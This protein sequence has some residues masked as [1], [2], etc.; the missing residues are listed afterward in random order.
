M[1]MARLARKNPRK[2]GR[3]HCGGRRIGKGKHYGRGYHGKGMHGKGM[4]GMGLMKKLKKATRRS[5]VRKLMNTAIKVADVASVLA[6]T[7]KNKARAQSVASA[8]RGIK[9]KDKQVR[10][11]VSG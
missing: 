8:A 1:A 6:T 9:K 10:K 4:H 7:D 2:V 5:N 11:A 3:G